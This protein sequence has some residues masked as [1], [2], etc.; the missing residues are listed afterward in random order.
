MSNGPGWRTGCEGTEVTHGKL[1][2]ADVALLEPSIGDGVVH[3]GEGL[4]EL[5]PLGFGSSKELGGDLARGNLQSA[6]RKGESAKSHVD[7]LG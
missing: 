6:G 7:T 4:D 2:A 1:R 5:G 3:V